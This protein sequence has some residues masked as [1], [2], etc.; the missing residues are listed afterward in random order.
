MTEHE[1]IQAMLP[2]AAADALDPAELAQV[3]RHAESCETCRR[4]L[5]TWSVYARGLSELPQPEAPV[6]LLERTRAR[7]IERRKAQRE[8]SAAQ[9]REVL[10]L[11]ALGVFGWVAGLAAWTLL[12]IFSGGVTWPLLSNVLALTTA[13]TAVAMLGR[14]N[15]I[16]RTL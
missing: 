1:S 14:R 9:R 7:V 4:E 6:G 2:L 16:A 12:R 8:A 13:A 5:Q 10:I 3:Q 15:E 11:V